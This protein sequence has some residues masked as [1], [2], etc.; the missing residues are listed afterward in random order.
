MERDKQ[1]DA[2]PADMDQHK[3]RASKNIQSMNAAPKK[4]HLPKEDIMVIMRPKDG[5]NTAGYSVARIGDCILRATGLKPDELVKDFA[6]TRG[7]TLL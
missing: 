2:K 6:S 4:P 1:G 5:F 3:R 7:R